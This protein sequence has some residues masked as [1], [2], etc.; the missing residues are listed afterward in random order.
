MSKKDA[1]KERSVHS[2]E[3]TLTTPAAPHYISG[4]QCS[5]PSTIPILEFYWKFVPSRE[6]NISVFSLVALVE[7]YG[8]H[9]T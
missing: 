4:K 8:Q 9:D 7:L 2:V 1:V 5:Y 6:W 3:G